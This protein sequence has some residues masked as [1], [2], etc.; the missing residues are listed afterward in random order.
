MRRSLYL[1]HFYTLIAIAILPYS[2]AAVKAA[3]LEADLE[4]LS[5][6]DSTS[7]GEKG[8][9]LCAHLLPQCLATV[10]IPDMNPLF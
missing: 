10:L 3:S 8:I 9:N 1:W 6:G 4:I 2:L 7:I 5:G